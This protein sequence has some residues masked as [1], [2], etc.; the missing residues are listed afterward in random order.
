M[1]GRVYR[2]VIKTK[3]YDDPDSPVFATEKGGGLRTDPRV[4]QAS[5]KSYESVLKPIMRAFFYL[6]LG[7]L[8]PNSTA[9]LSRAS[10]HCFKA[11]ECFQSYHL[12][13]LFATPEGGGAAP[14]QALAVLS[15][16]SLLQF[17]WVFETIMRSSCFAALAKPRR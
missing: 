17:I 16:A 4:V 1:R 7:G 12:S 6:Q 15:S 11:S 9:F 13:I 5:F 14:L 2:R 8:P 10:L 3:I